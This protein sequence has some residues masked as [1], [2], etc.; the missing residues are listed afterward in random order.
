MQQAG[1]KPQAAAGVLRNSAEVTLRHYTDTSQR[2]EQ[3]AAL[4][5]SWAYLMNEGR[6][7]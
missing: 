1:A 2:A 4:E 5:A 6:V 7:M 3:A